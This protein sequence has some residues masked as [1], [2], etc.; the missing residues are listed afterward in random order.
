MKINL[1]VDNR[2]KAII[3]L[4]TIP[5]T[6][7]NLEIGDFQF[8]VDD[9]LV[10]LIERKSYSDLSASIIDG[11]YRE[12]KKRILSQGIQKVIY[13]FE[14]DINSYKGSIPKDTIYSTIVNCTL[15]DNIQAIQSSSEN[16]SVTFIEKIYKNLHKYEVGEGCSISYQEASVKQKRN[17]NLTPEECYLHQLSQIPGISYP[18][19]KIIAEKYRNMTELID[20]LS[21]DPNLFVDFKVNGRKLGKKGQKIY[22][23]LFKI[24]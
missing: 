5:F 9:K 24:K 22:E 19:S 15:R 7:E 4:L 14:G 13:L 8:L 16:E 11:R 2:E 10:V 3:P 1:I 6:T 23:Y 20:S 21:S 18:T 17:K 12:Q